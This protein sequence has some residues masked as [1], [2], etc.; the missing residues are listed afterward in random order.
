M[1]INY[2]HDVFNMATEEEYLCRKDVKTRFEWPFGACKVY[3]LIVE[4]EVVHLGCQTLGKTRILSRG[5][6]A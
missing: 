6:R 4:R 3:Q 2:H 5:I 1:E